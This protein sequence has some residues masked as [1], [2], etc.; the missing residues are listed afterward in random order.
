MKNAYGWFEVGVEPLSP[1][2]Q[3]LNFIIG[4]GIMVIDPSLSI[5]IAI[6]DQAITFIDYAIAIIDDSKSKR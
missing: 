3:I 6:I 4:Q 2:M 5:V 1:V